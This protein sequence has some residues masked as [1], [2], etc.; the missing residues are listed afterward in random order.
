M[1]IRFLVVTATLAA[2]CGAPS[3]VGFPPGVY[4]LAV[5]GVASTCV[6]RGAPAMANGDARLFVDEA[7]VRVRA[8]LPFAASVARSA[9]DVEPIVVGAD[10]PQPLFGA[11]ALGDLADDRD[12]AALSGAQAAVVVAESPTSFVIDVERTWTASGDAARFAD[13]LDG[14]SSCTLHARVVG[15]LER[16]CDGAC[17]VV[18]E[19]DDATRS[20]CVCERS[21]E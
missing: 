17:L 16:A 7:V 20:A 3:P 5:E 13:H 15:E 14:A 21:P 4:D 2:A 11:V 19:G 10:G 6:D 18:R 1:R 12:D 9:A 8:P